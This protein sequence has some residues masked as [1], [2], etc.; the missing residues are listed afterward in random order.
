MAHTVGQ[1]RDCL[2]IQGPFV[3]GDKC[4]DSGIERLEVDSRRDDLAGLVFR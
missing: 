3:R 4:L 1:A 2:L